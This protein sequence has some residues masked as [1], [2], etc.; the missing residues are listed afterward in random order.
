MPSNA[1][2]TRARDRNRCHGYCSGVA[3]VRRYLGGFPL[4]LKRSEL[5]LS[6]SWV[7]LVPIYGESVMV[8]LVGMEQ[9]SDNLSFHITVECRSLPALGSII[10]R[11]LW[12]PSKDD[13]AVTDTRLRG[14]T[15][16][17]L[18]FDMVLT[19]VVCAL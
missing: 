3:S 16:Q 17:R 5:G 13:V 15:A 11:S 12:S 19:T 10:P 2:V 4:W 7:R 18:L 8:H 14:G 1:N 6:L 9:T